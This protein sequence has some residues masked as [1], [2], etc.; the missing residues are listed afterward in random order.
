MMMR[1]ATVTTLASALLFAATAQAQTV[2]TTPADKPATINQRL[3]SQQDRIQ[4]G[5]QDDQLTKGEATRL[6]ADDAAVHAE[7]KVDRRAN[8]GKLTKG[9]KRQLT[10]QLN[11]NSR[12]IHRAR[13]NKRTPQS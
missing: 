9:E 8:G 12:R 11:R 1:S 13:H 3:E 10:R 5:V 4:A 2:P 7:A 6:K